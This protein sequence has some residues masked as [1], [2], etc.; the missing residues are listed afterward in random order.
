[1]K[2][3]KTRYLVDRLLYVILL[4]IS[5]VVLF[6]LLMWMIQSR[7]ILFIIALFMF[8]ILGFVFYLVVY[9]PYLKMNESLKYILNGYAIMNLYKSHY[10]FSK[11]MESVFLILEDIINTKTLI[12]ATKKQAEYLALQN[13]INPHF[14]Y[15]TLES[16][17]AEAIMEDVD[18]VADV[19]ER[20]ANFY[21]YTISN[22]DRMVTIKEE[23]NHVQDYIEIQRFRFGE[24]I[25]L[26]IQAESMDLLDQYYIPKIILQ[27][28]VEN[29]VYHGLERKIGLGEIV[30]RFVMSHEAINIVI[31]D[32]GVGM[33][34]QELDKLRQKL[35]R[36]SINYLNDDHSKG[37]IALVN[38][39]TRIDLLYGEDYG[40]SIYSVKNGGTDVDIYLPLVKDQVYEKRDH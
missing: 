10:I 25:S 36:K 31:S 18:T 38:V 19:T 13:Q 16:I 14:L 39:S 7:M 3:F 30:I 23:L 24:K 4:M 2:D 8:V 37:G 1:M 35:N 15:N 28:I 12:D 21:R 20:L 22:I 9:R 32:N 17:R 40:L 34:V 29:A 5:F 27:P 6:L 11:E 33:D 26:T